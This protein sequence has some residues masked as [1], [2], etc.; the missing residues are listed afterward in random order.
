MNAQ[1]FPR[2]SDAGSNFAILFFFLGAPHIYS[3]LKRRSR[4]KAEA[5]QT[6][7]NVASVGLVASGILGTAAL[8]TF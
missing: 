3:F 8:F 5:Q 6:F 7:F 1:Q 4:K 2:N